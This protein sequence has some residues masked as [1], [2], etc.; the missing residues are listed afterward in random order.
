MPIARM[1]FSVF[2]VGTKRAPMKFFDCHACNLR[3][4]SGLINNNAPTAKKINATITNIQPYCAQKTLQG[5]SLPF[6]VQVIAAIAELKHVRN[7]IAAI[8]RDV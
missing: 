2:L 3:N 5:I 8:P 7:N 4:K 1:I 6:T